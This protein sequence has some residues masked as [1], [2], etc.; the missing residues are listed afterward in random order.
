MW[1]L[2]VGWWLTAIVSA[3]AWVACVTIIGLPLGIWTINRIPTVLT[4]RPRTSYRYQYTDEL[5]RRIDVVDDIEQPPWPVRGVW[6]VFVGWWLSGIA[7]TVAW[8]LCVLLITL[9]V[10]LIIYNRVPFVASLYR[11]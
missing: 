2:L 1:F 11:Y 4:L 8:V 3:L 9:P 6:F 7:M 10:G 5:G